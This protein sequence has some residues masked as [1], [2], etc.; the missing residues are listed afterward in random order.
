[1]RA[2][3]WLGL[4]LLF[5][6]CSKPAAPAG[7]GDA[8]LSRLE[9]A[10]AGP[11]VTEARLAAWLSWQQALAGLP[12]LGRADGGGGAE[13]RRRARQEAALLA[14]AGLTS[15]QADG[16]EAVV[17]AVVAERNVARLTGADA[18]QQFRAGVTQLGDEQRLKAEA[19]LADL[20][21]KSTQ[22][23]LAPVESQYGVEAV[24]VVLTREPE[25]TK[26]WDALLEAR[27]DKR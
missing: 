4:F 13:L 5:L 22:G 24:R 14:A 16:I 7:T 25:V 10:D 12:P 19:A 27:G 11:L 21:A 26:T 23:S 2:M 20:Q 3:R 1:M 9:E 6:G 15:D 17:A 8:G 18:L